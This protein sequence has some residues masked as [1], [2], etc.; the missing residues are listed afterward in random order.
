MNRP[1]INHHPFDPTI[2]TPVVT[3]TA[4]QVEVLAAVTASLQDTTPDQ[5]ALFVEELNRAIYDHIKYH[6]PGG[7]G[8]DGRDSPERRSMGSVLDRAIN[9]HDDWKTA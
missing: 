3:L 9:H 6:A 7:E 5:R 1:D 8:L 2:P 4:A